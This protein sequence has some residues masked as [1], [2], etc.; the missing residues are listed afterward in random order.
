MLMCTV[1]SWQLYKGSGSYR[2]LS[3]VTKCV[4]FIDSLTSSPDEGGNKTERSARRTGER[5]KGCSKAMNCLYL[6]VMSI[7]L[8]P[9]P[10]VL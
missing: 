9:Y 5:V 4:P 1:H 7:S 3:E 10:S 2:L 8:Q 6:S